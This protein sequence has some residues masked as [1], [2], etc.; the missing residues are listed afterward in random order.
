MYFWLKV[1][2][3]TALSIWFTGLFFLPRVF[4][5]KIKRQAGPDELEKLNAMGKTLYF[6]L[7]TPAA[8]AT[9]L[10]G[11]ALIAYGFQG[12]WFPVKLTL[13]A[14][15][16]MTHIYFGQLLLDLTRG[17]TRH[18]IWLFRALSWWPLVLLL[19]IATLTGAKPHSLLVDR[20]PNPLQSL[21][22]ESLS[23]SS[24]PIES[25]PLN[26]SP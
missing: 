19:S 7:M 1:I 12:A 15:L 16:V 10:A 6:H 17:R 3:I 22:G 14:M 2:H 8:V 21:G 9:V 24:S 20:L 25:S 4:I 26:S 18:S 13:V 23:S 5:A 11:T